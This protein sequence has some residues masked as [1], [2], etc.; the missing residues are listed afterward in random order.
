VGPFGRV[1]LGLAGG[2]LLALAL[3]ADDAAPAVVVRV[4]VQ[5]RAA[6]VGDHLSVR[7]EVELP[8]GARLDPPQLGPSL[9]PFSV[10]RGAWAGPVAQDDRRWTWS[11]EVVSFRTGELT[12]PSVRMVVEDPAG[13]EIEAVSEPLSITI[14]SVLE[15]QPSAD[16]SPE[17]ADLKAPASIAP[18]YGPVLTGLGI[19]LLLLLGAAL[20]W[21][22][23]RRYA[24][25]LAAVPAPHDPFHRM[26]PHEWFYAEL[27]K[28]LD[29]RLAEQGEVALF[30][31]ELARIVK[32]YLGGRYRVQIM[33]QTTEEVPWRLRQAGAE[34]SMKAVAELL[35]H[36]DR[37]KFARS[38]PD[39]SECRAAIEAAYGIVDSTR[40]RAH[41]ETPA[42]KGAA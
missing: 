42:R 10:V 7:I 25:R 2:A 27:Q 26:P 32:L 41:G 21:W 33:E 6:T 38:T 11:G 20:L 23:Q 9:G 28:L 31:E 16:D 22:L 30:F 39:E 37:V 18:D 1:A 12:F 34:S 3:A 24:S 36:C 15:P 35:G 4:E 5:P 29:R 19:V 17:L 14:T 40:P 13:A 8:P